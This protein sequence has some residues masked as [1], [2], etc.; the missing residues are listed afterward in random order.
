MLIL[1][2]ILLGP[3]LLLQGRRLRKTA[4]RLPEASGPRSGVEIPAS[5]VSASAATAPLRVLVVG[6]SSAAGVGVEHQEQA[7]AQPLAR[8]LAARSGRPVAWQL[9]AQS[10]VNSLEA[11]DLLTR[12]EIGP[13]T[14]L[15]VAL[16]VNDVTSQMS[17]R[18]YV[19]NLRQLSER[20]MAQAGV[21][22]IVFS[23][24]P[25]MHLLPLAPQP[26]RWYL[27]RCARKLDGALRA[28]I[29]R[30]PAL[31]YCSLQWTLPHDMALD[32]FHP[33]PGQYA[34]WAVMCAEI[35]E[36][37]FLRHQ[38]VTESV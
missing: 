35:V 37:G 10:G 31:R 19:A 16:G 24:L 38:P 15:V 4:L 23:G 25:P 30:D 7:L 11:L 5:Y 28:W 9:V 33:G 12:H 2:K 26:L 3:L 14:V 18:R 13:A 22:H 21:E 36:T 20:L 27:G 6:D 29:G 32:R 17:A 8:Q 1:A 34:Q